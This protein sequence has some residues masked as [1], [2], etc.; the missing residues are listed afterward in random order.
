MNDLFKVVDIFSESH[1]PL[2]GQSAYRL[3][4]FLYKFLLDRNV[5]RFFQM[6]EM[7]AQVSICEIEPLLE[8]IELGVPFDHEYGD[9][10]QTDFLMDDFVQLDSQV[11]L[12]GLLSFPFAVDD[13]AGNHQPGPEEHSQDDIVIFEKEYSREDGAENPQRSHY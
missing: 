6:T 11:F 9:N 1:P 13:D 7:S 8:V 3:G 10:T 12:H 2:L 5:F 4:F